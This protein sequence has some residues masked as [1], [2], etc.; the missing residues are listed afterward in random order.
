LELLWE[1]V[2]SN[3]F[4][5]FD[6]STYENLQGMEYQNPLADLWSYSKMIGGGMVFSVE[7]YAAYMGKAAYIM[8]HQFMGLSKEGFV[9][10]DFEMDEVT[11]RP[12]LL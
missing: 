10:F 2:C 11:L 8:R 12:K 6:L 9:Y 5:Y 3:H 4:D 7:G 1:T